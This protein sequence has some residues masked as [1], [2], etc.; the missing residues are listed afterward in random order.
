M[1]EEYYKSNNCKDMTELEGK[2]IVNS[3]TLKACPNDQRLKLS[4]VA[5]YIETKPRGS[6]N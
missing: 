6:P 1:Y 4:V 3:Q 2:Q 5:Y